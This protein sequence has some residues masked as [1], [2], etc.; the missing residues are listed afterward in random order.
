MFQMRPSSNNLFLFVLALATLLISDFSYFASI[1]ANQRRTKPPIPLETLP[2][3]SLKY[4]DMVSMEMDIPIIKREP[5]ISWSLPARVHF[6]W[7]GPTMIKDKYV[8]NINNF[9]QHNPDY[10]VLRFEVIFT[11]LIQVMLWLERNYTR[12]HLSSQVE[13]RDVNILIDASDNESIL[14]QITR[15]VIKADLLRYEVFCLLS[16]PPFYYRW[17]SNME[18]S[19]LTPTQ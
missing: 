2:S 13:I 17:F 4:L 3:T 9:C 16:W 15:I 8:T 11:F 6:I 14:R 7:I 19:T 1:K 18:V 5:E 10:Q 12:T